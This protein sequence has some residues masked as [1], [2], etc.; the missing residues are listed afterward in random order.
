MV[1]INIWNYIR[2]TKTI[3][4]E[5]GKELAIAL[6]GAKKIGNGIILINKNAN[7]D[8]VKE[9]GGKVIEK[10]GKIYVAFNNFDLFEEDIAKI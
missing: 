2:I 3:D 7:M 4:G 6:I 10:N 9:N 5:M 8:V 1:K